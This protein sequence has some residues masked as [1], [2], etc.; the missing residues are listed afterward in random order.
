M[1]IKF[2]LAWFAVSV[3]VSMLF[4]SLGREGGTARDD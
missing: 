1:L 4:G 2:L 3:I